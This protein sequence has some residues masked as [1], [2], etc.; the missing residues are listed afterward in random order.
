MVTPKA[1]V[2]VVPPDQL[3]C[4]EQLG[5]DGITLPSAHTA[6]PEQVLVYCTPPQRNVNVP[7]LLVALPEHVVA[8][9]ANL[10]A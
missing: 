6:F 1:A 4:D 5:S 9:L 3:T 2:I 8:P 10:A 7:S